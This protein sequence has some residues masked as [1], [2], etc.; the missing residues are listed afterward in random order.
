MSLSGNEQAQIT[1]LRCVACG[2]THSSTEH[3]QCTFCGEMLD[4]RYDYRDIAKQWTAEPLA[5][6]DKSMW[7]YA[8]LLPLS[9]VAPRPVQSVGWTPLIEAPRL[10]EWCGVGRLRIKD[11]S[12][13]PSASLKD[14]A[15]AIAVA[16]ALSL[17]K[18][19]V[20]CTS[21]GNDARSLA[22][23][24]SGMGLK[25]VIFTPENAPDTTI[26]PLLALGATVVKVNGGDQAAYE[27]C[28]DACAAWDWYNRN[29]ANNPFMVEGEK[30]CGLELA[31]QTLG[32]SPDWA[33]VSVGSGCT[34]AGLTKGLQEM[35][36]MKVSD[37]VPRVLGVQAEGARPLVDAF[38]RNTET[39]APCSANT[40]ANSISVGAPRNARKALQAVRS[41]KG[42]LLSV[43]DEAIL[44][45]VQVTA[46]HSEVLGEAGGVAG[47]AGLKAAVSQGIVSSDASV[48]VVISK[49]TR[50]DTSIAGQ[51]VKNAL[52]VE[53]S[54]DD[55]KVSLDAHGTPVNS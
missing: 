4:I 2:A 31:E 41:S 27:L 20:A 55:L 52:I 15:S 40:I 29:S 11:E 19:T 45:A 7:R 47:I 26:E 43:S 38:E 54:L 5:H 16:H 9:S 44:E 32:D 18:V 13:N 1:E 8:E 25:A 51:S 21:T 22:V 50:Q 37:T 33:V 48:V 17:G 12:R 39:I 42:H 34:I 28:N 23:M 24:A 30:T 6:R 3:T 10:A 49:S 46:Q 36:R 53:P 35:S 14:R